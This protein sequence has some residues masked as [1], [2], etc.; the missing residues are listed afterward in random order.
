MIVDKKSQ[1][2]I[3]A[4]SKI[5]THQMDNILIHGQRTYLKKI[6]FKMSNKINYIITNKI[7]PLKK[8][9]RKEIY[10]LL[11]ETAIGFT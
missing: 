2:K 7:E 11:V 3:K 1:N 5:E 6:S 10:I 4:L 8:Y 9:E